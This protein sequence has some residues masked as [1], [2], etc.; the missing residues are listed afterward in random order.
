MEEIKHI[1]IQG[2]ENV[3]PVSKS[4]KTLVAGCLLAFLVKRKGNMIRKKP[5]EETSPVLW[6]HENTQ[7]PICFCNTANICLNIQLPLK[8]IQPN[9]CQPSLLQHSAS[10]LNRIPSSRIFSCTLYQ[11]FTRIP[12]STIAL[13]SRHF[14]ESPAIITVPIHMPPVYLPLSIY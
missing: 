1:L 12:Y 11:L 5:S 3:N 8:N 4:S 9:L 14:T 13:C 6:P 10:S 7:G 2:R